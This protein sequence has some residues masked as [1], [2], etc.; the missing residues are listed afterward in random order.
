MRAALRGGKHDDQVDSTAQILDW[1]KRSSGP[2]SDAGIH[3]LYKEL[4]ERPHA[5]R[6]EPLSV[7]AKRLGLLHW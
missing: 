7:M 5:A 2:G 3:Q 1:F 6:P 4:A